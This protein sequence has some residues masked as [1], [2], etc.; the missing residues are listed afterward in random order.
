[1]KNY[2][3]FDRDLNC[4]RSS[5]K[6]AISAGSVQD[7]PEFGTRF[8][9]RHVLPVFLLVR[10]RDAGSLSPVSVNVP[11]ILPYWVGG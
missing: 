1:M 2:Q 10:C 7:V 11:L 4:N 8:S 9:E 5:P 6:I 3:I